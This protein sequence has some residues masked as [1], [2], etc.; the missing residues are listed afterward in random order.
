KR[1][2]RLFNLKHPDTPPVY[3]REQLLTVKPKITRYA[4]GI[5][6]RTVTPLF[7]LQYPTRHWNTPENSYA[8]VQPKISRHATGIRQRTV[9]PPFNL[10]ISRH[11]TGIR[12]RTVTPLFNLKQPDT[13]LVFARKQSCR[14]LIKNNQTRHWYSPENSHA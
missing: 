5:R 10:K 13:P 12:Q 6:L 1:Q 11:A 8:T 14:C 9:T 7:N 4:I 3:A 2:T